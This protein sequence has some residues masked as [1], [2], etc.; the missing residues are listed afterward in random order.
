MAIDEFFFGGYCAINV[1]RLLHDHLL[2]TRP[3][4]QVTLSWP[5]GSRRSHKL[6]EVAYGP[7][8]LQ[9]SNNQHMRFML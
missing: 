3:F 2:E 1:A 9:F 4:S 8:V 7:S 6:K 5:R